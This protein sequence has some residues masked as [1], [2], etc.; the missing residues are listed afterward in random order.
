MPQT[1]WSGAVSFGLVNVPVKLVSATRDRAVRF[2][3]LHGND[4]EKIRMKRTCPEHGEIPYDEVVKGY[5]VGKHE[6]VV[7]T[8][9]ELSSLEPEKGRTIDI[10]EFVDLSEVDPVFYNKPYHLVP[11]E[12]GSKAYHLLLAAMEETG[13]AGVGRFVLRNRE[14]L[15]VLRPLEGALVLET[16]RFHDEVVS[17]ETALSEAPKKKEPAKK[18][19]DMAVRLVKELAAAWDPSKYEDEF[20][21]KVLKLVEKK[22]SGETVKITPPAQEGPVTE[23]LEKA[24]EKSL[25]EITR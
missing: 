4:G 10:E 2:S 13:M 15:V 25:S 16:L 6:F 14:H 20:R 21:D 11:D 5:A 1:V 22:K 24:L 23:D 9:E 12:T 8:P 19:L 18:E 7:V 17:P 3:Q